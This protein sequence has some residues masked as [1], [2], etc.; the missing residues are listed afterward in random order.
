MVCYVYLVSFGKVN[1]YYN[2]YF[3]NF[4]HITMYF[5][6]ITIL[7]PPNSPRPSHHGS[8]LTPPHFLLPLF[9]FITHW[10][11]FML[12]MCRSGHWT[13]GNLKR[14]IFL[15]ENLVSFP[16]Q[17]SVSSSALWAPPH[18]DGVLTGSMFCRPYACN[19]SF[20]E[21]IN[22]MKG[23]IMSKRHFSAI[24]LD[25]WLFHPFFQIIGYTL[26]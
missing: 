3:K 2:L 23:S 14:A 20:Y 16:E 17:P 13:I 4:M 24:L 19:H 26:I 8:L 6:I 1:M 5:F 25:T 11:Q 7:H 22:I 21:F 12:L 10:I 9:F 18:L 15:K